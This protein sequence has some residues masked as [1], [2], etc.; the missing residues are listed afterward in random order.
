MAMSESKTVLIAGGSG[1]VGSRLSELLVMKGY[2]VQHLTRH[3]K[4]HNKYKS[5]YWNIEDYVIDAKCLEQVFAVINLAGSGIAEKPWTLKRKMDLYNSRIYAT[6][7]LYETLS[8]HQHQVQCY[9]GASAIGYYPEGENLTESNNAGTSF[10]SS[11]CEK[12]EEESNQ[13]SQKNIR[14]SIVRIGL[15]LTPRGGMLKEILKPFMLGIAPVF[16]SG[17]QWQSWIHIDDL[18]GVIIH[19]ME[20]NDLNGTFNAVAPNPVRAIDMIRSIQ[21]SRK[22]TGFKLKIPPFLLKLLLG[23]RSTMLLASQKVSS[24]KLE[25]TGYRFLYPEIKNVFNPLDK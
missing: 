6:R 19:L 22:Y 2:T 24:A 12:W 8:S 7:L 4:Q 10:L 11:L 21:L 23:E 20:R 15:V 16:G 9:I 14:T 13:L 5:F 3:P 1:L 25:S 18:C 17:L